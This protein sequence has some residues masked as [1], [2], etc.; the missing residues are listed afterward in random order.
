MP[1]AG[2]QQEEAALNAKIEKLIAEEIAREKARIEAEKKRKAEELAR[3]ERERQEREEE[4]KFLTF[5]V[6]LTRISR[7]TAY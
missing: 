4:L 2:E 5:I 1:L 6:R 3:K 7:H